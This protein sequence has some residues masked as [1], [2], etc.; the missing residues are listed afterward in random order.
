MHEATHLPY[1]SWCEFCRRGKAKA[2]PHS[3]ADHSN[4]AVPTVGLDFAFLRT[5]SDGLILHRKSDKESESEKEIN[6]RTRFKS[7][8]NVLFQW[9]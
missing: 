4:D 5:G 1:R 6:P 2:H 3:N 9:L 8:N 7:P